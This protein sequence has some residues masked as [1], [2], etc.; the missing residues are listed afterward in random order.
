MVLD[1]SHLDAAPFIRTTLVSVASAS[2][3]ILMPP[4]AA[5]AAET[6]PEGFFEFLFQYVESLGTLGPIAFTVAVSIFECIPLFPTQPL[7]LASGLLFGTQTGAG[8]MLIGT[9]MAAFIAFQIARGVGRPLAERI[10]RHEMAAGDDDA[11]GSSSSSSTSSSSSNSKSSAVQM[12]LKEVEA[13]IEAGTV[14]QQGF[15]IFLLRM[16]PFIPFSA[17]NYILGLS[18]LPLAPYLTGTIISMGFWSVTYASVGGASRM[19]LQHGA[20]PDT[21]MTAVIERAGNLSGEVGSV[22]AVA[23]GVAAVVFAIVALKR[24]RAAN[25]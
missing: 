19:L 4:F 8:C 20:D 15:A 6:A 11:D 17:C 21:L 23:G 13:V 25:A 24:R 5:H 3:V 12:K 9:S 18:P 10:I 14:W 1:S 22:A 7:S 16:T 2:G